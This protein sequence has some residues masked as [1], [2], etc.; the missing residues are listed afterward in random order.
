MGK[1]L[2]QS[3]RDAIKARLEEGRAHFE[4]VEEIN[5][6][7]QTVKNYSSTLKQ[8]D[9]VILSS[10]GQKGRKPILTREIVEVRISKAHSE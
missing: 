7:V 3:K 9:T 2:P 4:I 6:S 8:Y 5:V 1:P 10:I